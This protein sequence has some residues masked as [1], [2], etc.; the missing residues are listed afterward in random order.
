MTIQNKTLNSPLA[1]KV[2]SRV[3]SDNNVPLPTPGQTLVLYV[4]CGF[5]YAAI[6]NIH[7]GS[8][9]TWAALHDMLFE[10]CTVVAYSLLLPQY[11]S[12]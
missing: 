2:S 5:M 10:I 3:L 12:T 11:S 1:R 8:F 7:H 4:F 6:G 9:Y